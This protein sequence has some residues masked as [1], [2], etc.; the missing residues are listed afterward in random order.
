[1]SIVFQVRG[2]LKRKTVNLIGGNQMKKLLVIVMS[3][4]LSLGMLASCS[5]PAEPATDEAPESESVVPEVEVEE[6]YQIEEGAELVYYPMWAETEIQGQIIAEAAEAFTAQTGVPVHIEWTGARTT[7]DTLQPLL[8][9]GE[10]IDIFDEAIDSINFTFK[11]YLYDI[12]DMYAE[13]GLAEVHNAGLVAMAEEYGGGKVMTIPYQPAAGAVFYNKDAFEAAG[14]EAVPTTYDE[15]TAACDALVAAGYIPITVDDAYMLN[16]FS[17][18]LVRTAG[19]E[20]T[21]AIAMG[22]Y[23]NAAVLE[24]ATVLETWIANGWMDPRAAGNVFPAGQGNF[25]DESVAMY[26][27]ATWFP[28]EISNQVREDF[29][30]GAFSLPQIA[31]A[32]SGTEGNV[33]TGQCFGINKDTMYPVAAFEFLKYLTTGEWDQRLAT[34]S[35]SIPSAA[36]A[37]WPAGIADVKPILEA[38]TV[39]YQFAIGMNAHDIN[40][41]ATIKE[42]FKEL[43]A[44]TI[45]A[46][47]FADRFAAI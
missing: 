46:Q 9:Q 16:V 13:A 14:I 40:I 26:L 8:D 12:S 43:V 44:G 25:A 6:G 19:Y 28:N 45:D 5:T 42:V 22:D 7:R 41:E 38:T 36:D 18:I 2:L 23:G 3:L 20:A 32:G 27:N 35:I 30:F 21:E 17:H 11:D 15:F 37:E 34:E 47:E 31:E 29:R 10:T 33:L 4:A 1:M 24:A 39:T